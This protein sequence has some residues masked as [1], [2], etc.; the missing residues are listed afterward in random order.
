MFIFNKETRQSLHDLACGTYV[1]KE[2]SEGEIVPQKFAKIHYIFPGVLI[3]CLLVFTFIIE[4]N[5]SKKGVMP[6]L[7]SALEEL[8]KRENICSAQIFVGKGG[9][10]GQY[11]QYI[12]ST[13][14]LREEPE[15]RYSEAKSIARSLIESISEAK[16]KDAILIILSYGFDLGI[17]SHWN[18]TSFSFTPAELIGEDSINVYEDKSPCLKKNFKSKFYS[19]NSYGV[20]YYVSDDFAANAFDDYTIESV[21][22]KYSNRLKLSLSP[23]VN[24]HNTTVVD[25]IYE[26][27]DGSNLIAFYRARHQDIVIGFDVLDSLF[28]L[29]GCISVR[30]PKD[31]LAKQFGIVEPLGDTINIIDKEGYTCLTF[32][33]EN[34]RIIRISS[35]P[36]ID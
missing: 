11:S 27:T 20:P 4:P 25:T 28:K 10:A 7:F 36:G 34:N 31:S 16:E 3:L 9:F 14:T 30:M 23:F 29:D 21:K 35:Y 22:Q 5:L 24:K 1:V 32:Y 33:F 6:E 19:R 18:T 13:I 12:R 17:A 26:F 2:E 15:S 8:N